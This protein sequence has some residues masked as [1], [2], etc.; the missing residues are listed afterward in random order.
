[1]ADQLEIERRARA[2]LDS[3]VEGE[4]IERRLIAEFSVS[5]EEAALRVRI[6]KTKAAVEANPNFTNGDDEPVSDDAVTEITLVNKW[7]GP[8]PSSRR[9]PGK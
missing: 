6:V 7:L 9:R 3:G 2:L 4:E 5:A 1:M 8:K